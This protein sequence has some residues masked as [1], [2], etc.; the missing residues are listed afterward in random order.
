MLSLL[1]KLLAALNSQTAPY[2]LS[3]GFCFGMILGFTPFLSMHNLAVLLLV[4]SL[5]V[6]ISAAMLA[7]GL[8]EGIAYLLDQQFLQMGEYLLAL[9]AMQEQWT[10]MYNNDFWRLTHFNNTMTLGSLVISLVAFIP[11]FF[12]FN[13]LI[14]RYRK[15]VL[16][17][18]LKSKLM[19]ILQSKKLYAAYSKFS[20]YKS[21]LS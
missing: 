4:L 2:Q 20:D 17:W 3:L 9:P 1:F 8:F 21:A 14:K 19:Q 12:I 11:L 15:H 16:S 6:N 5:R 18:V 13:L 10:L 7:W